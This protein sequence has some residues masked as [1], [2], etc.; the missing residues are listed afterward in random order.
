MRRPEQQIQKAVLGHLRWRGVPNLWWAHFANGGARSAIEGAIF[1]GLGVRSGAPDVVLVHRGQAFFLELKARNGKLST[2]QRACHEQL[3][4]AGAEVSVA[5]GVDEALAVLERWQLL[6]RADGKGTR[7]HNNETD[8][9]APGAR[10]DGNS[11]CTKP[12]EN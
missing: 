2:V 3:R 4:Q 7:P 11:P 12:M 6:R 5:R 10:R 9:A 1:R 8:H